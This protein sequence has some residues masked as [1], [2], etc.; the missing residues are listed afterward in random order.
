MQREIIDKDI[1]VFY[2]DG[3]RITREEASKPE[4]Q[5]RMQ[6]NAF[7]GAFFAGSP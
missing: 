1:R 3:F 4:L 2:L 5:L 6:G 7:Q